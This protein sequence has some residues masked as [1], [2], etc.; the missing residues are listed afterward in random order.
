MLKLSEYVNA[1]FS[2]ISVSRELFWTADLSRFYEKLWIAETLYVKS[3][4]GFTTTL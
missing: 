2:V 4:G 1:E 3:G